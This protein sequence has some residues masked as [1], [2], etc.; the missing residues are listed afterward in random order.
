LVDGHGISQKAAPLTRA[1]VAQLANKF[2]ASPTE[3][4]Y[5][6]QL[7]HAP[8]S[9]EQTAALP[10]PT[11]TM[12]ISL[13]SAGTD[14]EMLARSLQAAL[15]RVGC[16]PGPIDG[17]WGPKARDALAEFARRSELSLS[18]NEPSAAALEAVSMYKKHVCPLKCDRGETVIGGHCVA[19]GT[20]TTH[21]QAQRARALDEGPSKR[22][23]PINEGPVRRARASEVDPGNGNRL[24]WSQDRRSFSVTTCN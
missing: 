21:T 6:M 2:T 4:E 12:P 23:R 18:T 10:S 24:C 8:I 9:S 16:D 3:S 5:A 19:K 20:D 17:A 7:Q 13:P 15:K 22:A 14:S 1:V 11:T